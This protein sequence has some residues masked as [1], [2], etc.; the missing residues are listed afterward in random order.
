MIALETYLLFVATAVILVVTPGPDTVF[1]L[2][3]TVASGA[4]PGFWTLIGT[5]CGNLIHALLAAVGISSLVLVLPYAFDVLKVLGA[6][7][8]VYLGLGAWRAGGRLSLRHDLARSSAGAWGYL[9]QGLAANLVNAKMIP[10]FIALF[11]Q[12]ITPAGRGLV[13]LALQGAL[14]GGTLALIA[15]AYLSLL[16]ALTGRARDAFVKRTNV[17]RFLNRAAALTFFAL[18]LRLA[19][20][21]RG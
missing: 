6:A 4:G 12:F 14:L 16:V 3:R 7:Y 21:E 9:R 1:V 20:S 2:S 8:L 19:V 15:V 13:D 18:A 17:I 10:F 11:P 5:Q